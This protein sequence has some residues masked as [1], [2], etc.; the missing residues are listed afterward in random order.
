MDDVN[1]TKLNTTGVASMHS[2]CRQKPHVLTACLWRWTC[3]AAAQLRHEDLQRVRNHAPTTIF[4]A[5]W[6]LQSVCW[7]V[8]FMLNTW[9]W[10]LDV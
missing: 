3:G 2:L 8:S 6:W 10:L 5:P 1:C 9:D 7:P 4:H